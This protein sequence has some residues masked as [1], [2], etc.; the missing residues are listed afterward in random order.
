MLLSLNRLFKAASKK[1][2]TEIITL[3]K[4]GFTSACFGSVLFSDIT[5]I[6]IP[7]R[8]ISLLAGENYDYY[9]KTEVDPPHL[10]ISITTENG[11]ILSWVL[12]EWGGLYNSKED[13]YTCFEF[14]T[15]LT[16]QL[17]RQF[18]SDDSSKSYLQI[19]D[20]T[21]YWERNC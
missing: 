16:N 1:L 17:F 19:L 9:K 5:S 14:L 7:A 3:D 12:N 11:K 21:G 13:F 4:D 15:A 8:E 18:Y 10:I 20:E 2:S 6:Q